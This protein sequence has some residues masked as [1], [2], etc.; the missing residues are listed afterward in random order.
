MFLYLKKKYFSSSPEIEESLGHERI[1][2]ELLKKSFLVLR[3]IKDNSGKN[4]SIEFNQLVDK[5]INC[6]KKLKGKIIQRL[7]NIQEIASCYKM[8]RVLE[9]F[10]WIEI[11]RRN[12]FKFIIED[13]ND[14]IEN[15][16]IKLKHYCLSLDI[17]ELLSNNSEENLKEIENIKNM[18][19][20]YRL[21]IPLAKQ[22]NDLKAQLTKEKHEKDVSSLNLNVIETFEK[23]LRDKLESF[24]THL[25]YKIGL[26]D[27]TIDLKYLDNI[28]FFIEKFPLSTLEIQS[29]DI[30]ENLKAYLKK[31]IDLK[32]M[33]EDFKKIIKTVDQDK[34][35]N[36]KLAKLLNNILIDLNIIKDKHVIIY[37]PAEIN[38][39]T[40]CD[41]KLKEF[42]DL[43]VLEINRNLKETILFETDSS[44]WQSEDLDANITVL[45]E[46]RSFL[47]NDDLVNQLRK[48]IGTIRN[49]QLQ[50][51][52]NIKNLISNNLSDTIEI[53]T[54]LL[55]LNKKDSIEKLQIAT[56]QN[57]LN[58]KV[59]N[60]C[61]EISDAVLELKYELKISE[62]TIINSKYQTILK[63]KEELKEYVDT[64]TTEIIN[65]FDNNLKESFKE[66]IT[67]E[68]ENIN[69]LFSKFDVKAETKLNEFSDPR[70]QIALNSLGVEKKL[71]NQFKSYDKVKTLN[72]QVAE[73]IKNITI[74][75]L[76]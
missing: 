18:V 76:R 61:K 70:I 26:D 59:K 45:L 48:C 58:L 3:N 29:N 24:N 56:L 55:R 71:L 51:F 22:I 38:E 21:I 40:S 64:E 8:L 30:K 19:L 4:S 35:N 43:L 10:S 28:D 42:H 72:N 37:C 41:K 32:K 54:N 68:F 2:Y 31:I 16:E 50:V 27:Q 66:L 13:L 20:S 63:V 1:D 47:N 36:L 62:F 39:K 46:F 60:L 44:L 6:I 5:L 33:D 11:Y 15:Q 73:Y 75:D 12:Y 67:N 65:N 9:N 53:K 17:D 74:N 25:K 52:Y 7:S 49:I 23:K 57:L 34:E 69:K 14:L